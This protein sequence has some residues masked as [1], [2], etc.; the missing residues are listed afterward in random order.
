MFDW[1]S[2]LFGK[3]KNRILPERTIER[4]FN[5]VPAVSATMEQNINLWY[6]E[7][8]GDAPWLNCDVRPLGLPAAI[9]RELSRP[10]L[11]EF[12]MT[13]IGSS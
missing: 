8:I 12:E 5:A 9:V 6:S 10:V 11:T 1:L 2:G 4:A 13:V 3:L 7:Y